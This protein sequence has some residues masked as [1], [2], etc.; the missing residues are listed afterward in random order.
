M[1]VNTSIDIS[2]EQRRLLLDL[3]HQHLPNTPIWAFGSRVKWTTRSNSDLDLVAFATPQQAPQVSA[4]KEAFEESNLPF[5]VDLLVWD[6]LPEN[7]QRNIQECYVVLME[8]KDVE[9]GLVM[10]SDWQITTIDEIKADSKSAIAIGP[11]GSNMK[12]ECY[13]NEG[14]P[15]IRGTN[16][17]G[18]P[19]FQGEFV[20]IT[21][22]LADK[23]KS[24][25]VNQ[26]DLV[27]PH[28][29]SIG[30]VGIILDDTRYVISSS[31][32][33]LTCDRSKA[34]P[35]FLYYFFKSNLGR[36]E[37]LKNA[38]QVGTPGI[39]QPLASLKSIEVKL[40]PLE[41]QNQ[42]EAILTSLD[43]KIEL[44]R[45]T[46]QTLEQIAQALFKS[47]FVDFEPVKAKMAAKQ[48]GASAEQIEQ[49]ALCAISGKT[50]EQ[51]T[52]LNPQTL[53]QLKTTAALFPDA[54]VDSE[55]GEIPEGW[56]VRQLS[57]IIHVI[58][59]GTPTRS[60]ETYWNDDIPWFSV[61][62]VPASG[63]VF[64]V[65]TIEKISEQGLRKS[66]TKLLPVGTTIITARG[67]VGKLALVGT[68]ICMN[69][70]CYGIRG[71]DGI[72]KY[73]NYF[74]LREAITTLQQNTHGAVFDTITTQTFDSYSMAICIG[75][76]T[77]KFDEM[78]KPILERIESNVRETIVLGKLRDSIL[79]KLL[80]GEITLA[81]QDEAA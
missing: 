45:Q 57:S 35:K 81:N 56:E 42:I 7:F 24:S 31:L 4:L 11:F 39:G 60:E 62:D 16:I 20:Y 23:L 40:P 37:L 15:V 6:K 79:P 67:T 55:L 59:G 53:Q 29:G 13:V 76:I 19:T 72:G 18:G 3:I 2:A 27:F 66:S 50:P 33:K 54:L 68:P 30:E 65:D 78:V 10:S 49:A 5:R 58:G 21:Q 9:Q 48:A 34:S 77:Q 25:N 63:D 51:L 80:S 47:W 36:H 69:Q 64:V 43:E 44:N 8:G 75:E 22:E 26:Y 17:T 32:M 12:S 74:N 14:V 52:Q 61:K 73:F 71:I 1:G 28:R 41:I 46:N 38:S 70:S